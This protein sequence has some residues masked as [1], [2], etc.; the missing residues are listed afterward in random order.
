MTSQRLANAEFAVMELLWAEGCLTARDIQQRLYDGASKPQHGTVQKLLTRLQT[1]GVVRREPGQ[2]AHVFSANLTRDDYLSGQM[3][4]V[5]ERLSGGS[6]A[7]LIS[8][9]IDRK[10]ISPEEIDRLRRLL[11]DRANAGGS[12]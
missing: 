5:A 4:A 3:E 2:R 9:L 11:N 8:N 10:R 12:G 6:L 1:K 7:P